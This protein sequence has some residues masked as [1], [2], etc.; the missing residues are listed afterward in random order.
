M[1]RSRLALVST[2]LLLPAIALAE[3]PPRGR[4]SA[5]PK[6]THVVVKETAFTTGG[7]P[8]T[9]MPGVQVVALSKAPAPSGKTRV[10]VLYGGLEFEG[11]VDG[12]RLGSCVGEDAPLLSPDGKTTLGKA[13]PGALVRVLGNGAKAGHVL[14]ETQ[15][16]F[17]VKAQLPREAV[18]SEAHEMV[19][20]F[21]W[22]YATAKP[23]VLYATQE[24]KGQGFV[25]LPEGIQVEA[26]EQAGDV[27]HV[28][29][30][31]GIELDGWTPASNLNPRENPAVPAPDPNLISPNHEVFVDAPVF[32][33]PAGRRRIGTLRGGALVE[34]NPKASA[35][36]ESA[37]KAGMYKI[38]TPSPVVVEAWVKK[39]DV[40][41]LAGDAQ[42]P[43]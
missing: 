2:L 14:V 34:V 16:A 32:A 20:G 26:Y 38:V 12:A 4:R 29:T 7:G 11:T 19:L 43:M 23:T 25:R 5:R 18:T 1:L 36:D 31:G 9:L 28:H 22:N 39:T 41:P 6:P 24:L 27:L 37:V 35:N 10:T 33:D 8:A 21:S 40:R 3:A 42:K 30:A 13:H 17:A 15:G